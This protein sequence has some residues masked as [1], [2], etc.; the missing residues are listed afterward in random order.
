[1]LRS[2]IN[3]FSHVISFYKEKREHSIERAFLIDDIQ[4]GASHFYADILYHTSESKYYC[5]GYD[6]LIEIQKQFKNDTGLDID[7]DALI[8]KDWIRLVYGIVR[9]P[10]LIRSAARNVPTVVECQSEITFLCTIQKEENITK[11]VFLTLIEKYE[12]ENNLQL[13][14]ETASQH[15]LFEEKEGNIKIHN[16]HVYNLIINHINEFRFIEYFYN[17]IYSRGIDNELIIEK[18]LF[19]KIIKKHK[20]Y[21]LQTP[22]VED[23]IS[24]ELFKE[25]ASH[26]EVKINAWK[27][28]IDQIGAI[29]WG[30]II[31]DDRFKSDTDR[32]KFWYN[33]IVY[34]ESC[35]C[36]IGKYFDQE[37]K[38]RFLKVASKIVTSDPDLSFGEKEYRKLKLDQL[39]GNILNLEYALSKDCIEFPT[40]ENLYILHDNLSLLDKENHGD[41]LY[42]QEN[43]YPLSFFI[44]QI[45]R[46]DSPFTDG[47]NYKLIF[48]LLSDEDLKPFILWQVCF[49]IYYWKPEIIPFLFLNKRTTSLGY[50][51][52]QK[53][54]IEKSIVHEVED[55]Q[56]SILKQGFELVIECIKSNNAV[57][58]DE[59]KAQVIFECLLD[60]FRKKYKYLGDNA[61]NQKKELKYRI[62]I[63]DELK[64]IFSTTLSGTTYY[65][66]KD[67][68][69]LYLYPALLPGLLNQIDGYTQVDFRQNHTLSLPYDK[70]DFFTW[71]L[72]LSQSEGYK[73][74]VQDND[75]LINEVCEA[76]KENYLEVINSTKVDGWDYFQRKAVKKQPI[77]SS[78]YQNSQ[79]QIPWDKIFLFL[80]AMNLLD[81]FLNPTELKLIKAENKYDE[82]NR[83]T[84]EK[85]RT[86]LS[87]LLLGFNSLYSNS[88]QLNIKKRPVYSTLSKLENKIVHYVTQYCIDEPNKKRIDIFDELFENTYWGNKKEEL[89][90]IVAFTINRFEEH[91]KQKILDEL[92]KASQLTRALKI[93]EYAISEKDR[94]FMAQII[95]SLSVSDYLDN[96]NSITDIQF[97]LETLANE[98]K[99]QPKAKEA[100][101][102]WET[103]VLKGRRS[104]KTDFKII[105]FRI[106]LLLAYHAEDENEI[107]KTEEPESRYNV[108]SRD[109]NPCNEKTF[110]RALLFLKNEEPQKAYNLFNE[111]LTNERE[112][113]STLALNRFA[114][115]VHW[116]DSIK[117]ITDKKILYSEAIEEWTKFENGLSRDISI[118]YIKEKIWL[119]KLHVYSM[120]DEANKFDE[121]YYQ[122]D[123]HIQLR[124]DF[125]ELRVLNLIIRKM[126]IQAEELV[127]EAEKY[128]K[129]ND[130]NL[131]EFL[132]QIKTLTETK[133]TREFLQ[134]QY[135]RIFSKLAKELIKIIPDNLN[136]YKTLENFILN[137]LVKAAD[138]M[139][140]HINSISSIDHEDKYSDLMIMSLNGRLR[141]FY[142]HIGNARGGYSD[143]NTQKLNPGEIDFAIYSSHEKIAICEAMILEGRN[144]VTTQKHNF[145]IF[146]YDHIRKLF[147]VI[148]YYKGEQ[149]KFHHYWND[150][151]NQL[152]GY[153]DFP[154]GYEVLNNGPEDISS[155]FG[156][157]CIKAGKTI[158]E[159]GTSLYHI[160]ININ[161]K[162]N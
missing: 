126:T 36:N 11:E 8:E 65:E 140:T 6:G 28:N 136:P 26:Y 29:L 41:L 5:V 138:I 68:H 49:E 93:L 34:E 10:N 135:I 47:K 95:N 12:K 141:A 31:D 44:H 132:Q 123:K 52:L 134:T 38:K 116:A 113:N 17:E 55:V 137:E 20:N 139:L 22:S 146:N 2:K 53:V 108:I 115:K 129:L 98:K 54:Q 59:E 24:K 1:M 71:I 76:I 51:L 150:Y 9:I 64:N 92:V 72:E 79:E 91:N 70:L 130:G 124:S 58:N 74:E 48:E 111:L 97:I 16:I 30:R 62:Q 152:G 45:V 85:I 159:N 86:H 158:H 143:S 94:Q 4:W 14:V 15:H 122:L 63:N 118:E 148:V 80:E 109:F 3:E 84:A 153:I 147:Y 21:F 105:A 119:N 89:L 127:A 77:W 83:F 149:D 104:E 131:P 114:S 102:F 106:K 18:K 19:D 88:S 46:N 67:R 142:W 32:M 121:I 90:P 50:R 96:L 117:V 40:S 128:H 161:Y 156:N 100:L 56:S 101:A 162:V 60:S 120:L 144:T 37:S 157:D 61:N 57:L 112:D 43:R 151:K 160:F 78:R 103:K 154:E 82:Y 66:P 155:E 27:V 23:L 99:F 73:E 110:Y 145:K 133:E 39:H 107:I 35:W 81:D 69:N 75:I 13:N 7:I 87:I 33:R 25:T 125:L 42:V